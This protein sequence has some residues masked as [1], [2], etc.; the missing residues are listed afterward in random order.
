MGPGANGDRERRP[1]ID[2][3]MLMPLSVVG[4]VIGACLWGDR[5]FNTLENQMASLTQLVREQWSRPD[6]ALFA[7]RLKIGNPTMTVPDVPERT[8]R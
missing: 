2:G 4:V 7:A 3:K 1:I 6:Q 8:D 5:R